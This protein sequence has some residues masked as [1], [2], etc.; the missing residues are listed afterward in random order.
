MGRHPWASRTPQ[1]VLNVLIPAVEKVFKDPEVIDR[2]SK[3]YVVA[4]YMGPE[5]FR[6]FIES[7]I[8]S[9]GKIVQD[10]GLREK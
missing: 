1:S 7:E 8:R 2:A 5:E 4:E 3:A 9:V 6:K 10:T